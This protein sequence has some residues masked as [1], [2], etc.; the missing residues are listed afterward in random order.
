MLV[1]VL[2]CLSW[3]QGRREFHV[4]TEFLPMKIDLEGTTNEKAFYNESFID[5]SDFFNGGILNHKSTQTREQH[6]TCLEQKSA[7]FFFSH[8]IMSI[9]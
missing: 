1:Y 2:N 9:L 6:G 5:H 8:N 7:D 3:C 4:L